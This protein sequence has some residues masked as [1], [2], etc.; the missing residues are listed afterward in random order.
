MELN[1]MKLGLFVNA[2]LQRQNSSRQL[3]M[4]E[5]T[6]I[7]LNKRCNFRLQS[8]PSIQG[9]DLFGKLCPQR[10]QAQ[11]SAEGIKSRDDGKQLEPLF[12]IIK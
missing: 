12:L 5:A 4:G 6:K 1:S 9:L 11:T 2:R 3:R 7:Y 10:L 8:S